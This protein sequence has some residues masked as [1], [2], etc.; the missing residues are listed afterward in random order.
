MSENNAALILVPASSTAYADHLNSF[1]EAWVKTNTQGVRV[2]AIFDVRTSSF[3]KQRFDNACKNLSS[4]LGT[5]N[6]RSLY[7]GT[8]ASCCEFMVSTDTVSTQSLIS[9]CNGL[10]CSVCKIVSNGFDKGRIGINHRPENWFRFGPGFYFSTLTSKCH[11]YGHPGG[12][13]Y[14]D[15]C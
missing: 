10:E 15:Y 6:V 7:H 1:H 2:E 11:Y 13:I 8:I 12:N 5:D 9:T 14:F 3:V 4:S